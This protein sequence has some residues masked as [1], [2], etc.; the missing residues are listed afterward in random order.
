MISVKGTLENLLTRSPLMVRIAL[1][2]E[3]L[4]TE[5]YKLGQ[6]VVELNQTVEAQQELMQLLYARQNMIMKA[7]E[8][9]SLD[10]KLPMIKQEKV[11]KPN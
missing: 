4:A 3:K 9:R 11:S 5:V 8:D 7:L 10:M 2:L 1:L 6:N